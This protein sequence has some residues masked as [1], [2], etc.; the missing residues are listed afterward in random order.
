MGCD[1]TN[2]MPLSAITRSPGPELARCEL[3]HLQRQPI[4]VPRAL[5]QHRDYQDALRGAGIRVIELASDP[6][7]PDGAFVEDTA[8]VLDELGVIASPSPP[9]RRGEWPAVVA[10]L[11]LF[12][13]LVRLP[14]DACLEGGD[15]VRMGRTL[16]VGQGGRTGAA[17][18]RALEEVVR[19]LGY[20]V[21]P[22]H[23]SG[24]LHLKSACCAV[25]EDTLLVNRAW[26]DARALSALRL[27]N[28]PAEEAWGANV[29]A[30][31]GATL[32]STAS[33][34]T[35][36]LLCRLG[37]T[38]LALDVS[39]LHKAEAGLTCMSLVFREE[40]IPVRDP[41]P[42]GQCPKP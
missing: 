12:R 40:T 27:V 20:S 35:I 19:P 33:P 8:V 24:C 6:A 15:V 5:A 11:S 14:P 21:V 10:A 29:L 26:L 2:D 34:R 25:D 3:T 1:G 42:S 41:L 39:E 22:V 9:S 17:G 23:L 37:H 16:F 30:L 7:L 38:A 13:N 36:D 32:V 4:D 31:S 18:L 28:V